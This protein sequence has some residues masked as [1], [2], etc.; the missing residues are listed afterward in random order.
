[1]QRDGDGEDE[2]GRKKNTFLDTDIHGIHTRQKRA[3][4]PNCMISEDLANE[5]NECVYSFA[6]YTCVLHIKDA[7]IIYN[8]IYCILQQNGTQHTHPFINNIILGKSIN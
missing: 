3:K 7:H 1:M 5:I 4:E 2:M 6:H 8:K